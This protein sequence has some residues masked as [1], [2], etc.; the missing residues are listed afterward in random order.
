M[1]LLSGMKWIWTAGL[2]VVATQVQAAPLRAHPCNFDGVGGDGRAR[3]DLAVFDPNT[4]NWFIFSYS[5]GPALA[6]PTQWGFAG[7]A[8]APGNYDGD[9]SADLAVYHRDSGNWYIRSMNGT[10]L[11]SPVNWG[12]AD[13]DAFP[14]DYDGD[15]RTDLGVYNRTTGMWYVRSLAGVV[16]IPGK[17]WGWT[18]TVPVPADYDGDGRANLAVYHRRAGTWYIDS[19]T[20]V[21]AFGRSWGWNGAWAVP[22]DYDGDGKAD[23]A[24]YDRAHGKWYIQTISGTILAWGVNWGW[25]EATPVPGDYDGDGRTDLAVYERKTGLWYIRTLGGTILSW[26]VNWGWKGAVPIQTYALRSSEGLVMTAFGDSITYGEGSLSGEPPTAYPVMLEKLM[27][28]R[29]GGYFISVN[30]GKSGEYT[31]KGKLR[32][33]GVLDQMVPD[34]LLLMEGV[35]DALY[36]YMFDATEFNLGEMVAQAQAR[37]AKVILATVPPTIKSDYADRSIQGGR[38]AAFNPFVYNVGAKYNIPIAPVYEYITSSPN[39]EQTMM[40]QETANHPSPA[41]HLRVR[42]AFFDAFMTRFY[43]GAYY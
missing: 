26:G 32:L 22:G 30:K 11:A 34:V 38:I 2:L 18:E 10:V 14:A 23:L 41:G 21:V 9:G 7:A 40:H 20:G 28:I 25:A 5:N 39:W 35:N 6:F 27:N 29:L 43:A 42:D 19:P 8:P 15:G 33:P 4:A 12:W 17:N 24:V 3:D 1:R 31:W 36:D 16:T 13:A 37:G